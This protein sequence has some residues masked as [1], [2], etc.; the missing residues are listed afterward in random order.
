MPSLLQISLLLLALTLPWLGGFW[1]LCVLES[2]AEARA[3][4]TARRLGYG[5]FAGFAA[6]QASVLLANAV[7]GQLDGWL[8]SAALIAITALGG[9]ATFMVRNSLEPAAEKPE[10]SGKQWLFWLFTGWA[11]LHLLFVAVEIVHRPVF[12][13]DAWLSWV[14]RAKAWYFSDAIFQLDHPTAWAAGKATAVYNVAGF[15]YPTFPSIITLWSAMALG[16]WSE[17][18]I[19][20]PTL[21]CGIA[22]GL[23]MYGQVR[24]LGTPRWVGA[25]AAYL[26]LSIPLIGAHLSLA[27]QADIWMAAFTGL[28]FVALLRGLVFDQRL[29]QWTGLAF[30]G[31]GAATKVEGGVWLIAGVLVWALVVKT[32]MTLLAIA[33][34]TVITGIAVWQGITHVELPVVGGLGLAEGR[35]HIPLLGSY[36]L[37]NFD[38][39][40]D[41]LENFFNSGTWHL[42]WPVLVVGLAGLATAKDRQLKLTLAI[43]FLVAFLAQLLI[44]EGTEQGAWAEDWTAI[45]R[46][47]LH[48]AP[49]LIFALVLI[50]RDHLLSSP[51]KTAPTH[52][53][54]I[55]GSLAAA[56]I[57][58][59]AFLSL[60]YPGSGAQGMTFGADAMQMRVGDGQVNDGEGVITDY[61]ANVAIISTDPLYLDTQSLPLLRVD[62]GGDNEKRATFFW[63][64]Q[65][66]P[67]ELYT[68]RLPGAGVDYVALTNSP[69]WSGTVTEI[70][71]IF[72]K[73]Q[74]REVRFRS[75]E[76][77]PYS[78]P[79]HIATLAQDWSASSRWSQRSVHW[80]PAGDVSTVLPLP[81]L[82]ALW[83]LLALVASVALYRKDRGQTAVVV[84]TVSL[85]AWC[86]LDLRWTANRVGQ[87]TDTVAD[88]P[89]LSATHQAFGDDNITR[90]L[91]NRAGNEAAEASTLIITADDLDMRFQMLRAK[92]HALPR[93][94]YVH[95]ADLKRLPRA[96]EGDLLVLRK[97]YADPSEPRADAAEW[98][99][100][101]QRRSRADATLAWDEAAGFLV[102]GQ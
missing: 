66:D 47:P 46:L 62:I 19:N 58:G 22:L 90:S 51:A 12:P 34:G 16:E 95:E 89:L 5:L 40:D 30:I 56:I 98:T 42:L 45:N 32:R 61:S 73:D 74:D 41:Y 3:G 65:Q 36:A 79:G 14:Y 20:L 55:A 88:Y 24:G 7:S 67:N 97:L 81:A 6:V 94:A 8:V 1:W 64:R 49:A 82:M 101:F 43:F 83:L 59:V 99:E 18:L 92:Y 48:F 60:Q 68:Q 33:A 75:A 38:L 2:R 26:V 28:G 35:L 71:F 78:V 96:V 84:I 76:L 86:L 77:R 31:M 102:K 87:T 29:Q 17:T 91:V 27:G 13:W 85:T 11:C 50:A 44:F 80:L 10:S 54:L 100:A 25:G 52:W 9:L 72:Y 37:Q 70:G 69:E 63:R 39:L 21:M 4:D 15:H 53:P 57:A 93:P 23:A